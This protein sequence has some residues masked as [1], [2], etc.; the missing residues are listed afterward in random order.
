[1]AL[2]V[3]GS[4][5]ADSLPLSIHGRLR[6]RTK[7]VVS[8]MAAAAMPASIADWMICEIAPAAVGR[9]KAA[10]GTRRLAGTRTLSILIE[11]EAVVRWPK[12]D[13]SLI[14]VSPGAARS[15]KASQPLPSSSTATMGTMCASSAPVV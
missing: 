7:A 3:K 9:S 6:V 15:A 1:M 14:T 8:A 13:Q 4:S 11:P 12:P 2:I 5:P 10:I